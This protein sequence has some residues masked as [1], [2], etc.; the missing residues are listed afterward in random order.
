MKHSFDKGLYEVEL[1]SG[2]LLISV[3]GDRSTPALAGCG[4]L[5]AMLC[6]VDRLKQELGKAQARV[7]DLLQGDDGQAF[8]EGQRY[9]DSSAHN[10]LFNVLLSEGGAVYD[11]ARRYLKRVAP[12]LECRLETVKPPADDD[13]EDYHDLAYQMIGFCQGFAASEDI[14]DIRKALMLTGMTQVDA[15]HVLWAMRNI[16]K[17]L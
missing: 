7:S 10:H 12:G 6:E 14:A 16:R 3:D 5:L 1:R 4:L 17:G 2:T 9:L 11:E 15:D 13:D 8:K